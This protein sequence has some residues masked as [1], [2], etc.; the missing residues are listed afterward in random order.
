MVFSIIFR[1]PFVVLTSHIPSNMNRQKD[2]MSRLDITNR[3][4]TYEELINNLD[5]YL[6]MDYSVCEN[7]IEK[8]KQ[9]SL[10][11]LKKALDL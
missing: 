3:Y 4:I 9:N 1:R 6:V 2:L 5:K 10:R 7:R 8:E 11:F